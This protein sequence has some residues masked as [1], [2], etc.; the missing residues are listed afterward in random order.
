[1]IRKAFCT[2]LLNT[3]VISTIIAAKTPNLETINNTITKDVLNQLTVFVDPIFDR[4]LKKVFFPDLY[5]VKLGVNSPG[6]NYLEFNYAIVYVI[7]GKYN[8][9]QMPSGGENLT[10]YKEII[11][12]NFLLKP[13]NSSAA[14][15]QDV[16]T[17]IEP[18]S[19]K[20]NTIHK[21]KYSKNKWTF[22]RSKFLTSTA[23]IFFIQIM[24]VI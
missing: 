1:M 6:S 23:V 11:N 13:N 18:I 3:V 24:M 9:L 4:K 14:L 10:Q 20:G 2:L 7:D 19:T 21:I 17:I 12:K 5:R 22:I 8:Y 16:L 15:L